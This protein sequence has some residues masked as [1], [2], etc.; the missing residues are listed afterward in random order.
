MALPWVLQH[1]DLNDANIFV[2]ASTGKLTGVIGW[3]DAA[4]LPFG[5]NLHAV[6]ALSMVSRLEDEWEGSQDFKTKDS[7]FWAFLKDEIKELDEDPVRM[8]RRARLLGILMD[9]RLAAG[10]EIPEGEEITNGK[11]PKENM[12]TSLRWLDGLLVDEKTRFDY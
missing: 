5:M 2:D 6:E 4:V 8:I 7:I 1:Q 11:M 9:D 10:G 12:E 3:T